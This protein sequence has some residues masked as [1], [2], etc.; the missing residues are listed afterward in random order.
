MWL[1]CDCD[2]DQIWIHG[3]R[4][5]AQKFAERLFEK[6]KPFSRWGGRLYLEEAGESRYCEWRQDG[7]EDNGNHMLLEQNKE[8]TGILIVC[9]FLWYS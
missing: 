3:R 6:S 9:I 8:R 2:L 4:L 7:L 5:R 1:T